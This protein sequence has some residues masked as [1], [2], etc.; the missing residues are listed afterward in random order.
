MKYNELILVLEDNMECCA[1]PEST[2]IDIVLSVKK[3]YNCPWKAA[4]DVTVRIAH[5][6]LDAGWKIEEP[7]KK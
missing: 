5:L 1:D 7:S 4:E 2:L 3:H 6:L